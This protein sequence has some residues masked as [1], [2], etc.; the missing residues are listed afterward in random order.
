MYR[1]VP[2]V[3]RR[4][5]DNHFFGRG[6][7]LGDGPRA[8]IVGL[9]PIVPR[10]N[11]LFGETRVTVGHPIRVGVGD[12]SH[13]VALTRRL[14]QHSEF[15]VV[16]TG[17]FVVQDDVGHCNATAV[18]TCAAGEGY[19]HTRMRVKEIEVHVL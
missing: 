8:Y 18:G 3:T 6:R 1:P 12:S 15:G 2:H 14:D 11:R 19:R 5:V 10:E 16:H 4:H 7:G 13:S 9:I 17:A